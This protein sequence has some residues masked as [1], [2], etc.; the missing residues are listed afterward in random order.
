MHLKYALKLAIAAHSFE[1]TQLPMTSNVGSSIAFQFFMMNG[2]AHPE[3]LSQLAA[4]NL[5]FEARV[6][7]AF[8][9]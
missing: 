9:S 4:L 3:S 2:V 5:F 8:Y 1:R 6:F 7:F